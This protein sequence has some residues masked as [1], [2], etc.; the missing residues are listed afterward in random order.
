MVNKK[1]K[2]R[3]NKLKK[4]TKTRT[5]KYKIKGGQ[6]NTTHNTPVNNLLSNNGNTGKLES[7]DTSPTIV[8]STTL[9][10]NMNTNMNT[11]ISQDIKNNNPE[12]NNVVLPSKPSIAN[13]INNTFQIFYD[14]NGKFTNIKELSTLSM[15]QK[16]D[17]NLQDIP[18][19][20][21][22]EALYQSIQNGTKYVLIMH[23]TNS[24]IPSN[25]IGSGI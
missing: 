20:K 18:Y 19:V 1:S 6:N 2:G 8:N 9:N 24:V 10:S 4:G 13:D 14:T 17:Y 16:N 21:L 11:K 23:D 25:S 7:T 12:K 5:K 22:S 3:M 15:I